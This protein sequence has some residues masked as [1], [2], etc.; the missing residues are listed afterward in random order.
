MRVQVPLAHRVSAARC[1]LPAAPLRRGVGG[2]RSNFATTL[3]GTPTA[4]RPGED[5]LAV[6]CSFYS[7][8][9]LSCFAFG[10]VD[11]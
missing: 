3:D 9:D 7:V 5:D 4:S 8:R 6:I 11:E 1:P 2:T 10:G